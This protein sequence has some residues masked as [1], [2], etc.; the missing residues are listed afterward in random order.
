VSRAVKREKTSFID[1]AIAPLI[2]VTAFTSRFGRSKTRQKLRVDEVKLSML[3][4]KELYN[5]FTFM[6]Y[7]P[8]KFPSC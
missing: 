5:S 3:S 6:K 2:Y 4:L 8:L 1:P 7:S